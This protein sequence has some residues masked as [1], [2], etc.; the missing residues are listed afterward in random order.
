MN[1]KRQI[2]YHLL[3]DLEETYWDYIESAV[4]TSSMKDAKEIIKFIMEKK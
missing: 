1:R 4:E 2:L 3:N